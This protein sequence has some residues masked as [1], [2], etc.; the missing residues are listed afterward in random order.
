MNGLS[1]FRKVAQFLRSKGRADLLSNLPAGSDPAN[2]F[3]HV[4]NKELFTYLKGRARPAIDKFRS[5]WD[6]DAYELHAH[7]D[8]VQAFY[9]LIDDKEV[10]KA[11]AYGIPVMTDSSGR[12]FAWA[13]GTHYVFI[14]LR[15]ERQ[16]LARREG[17]R[18]DPSYGTE[19][20][21]FLVGGRKSQRTNSDAGLRR[22]IRASYEDLATENNT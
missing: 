4:W 9:D 7:P 8:L 16:E 14:R 6:I 19:W 21:E 17:G 1:M 22:W 15:A 10:K 20:V 12:V 11:A 3:P 18:L 13:S 5:P 2:I